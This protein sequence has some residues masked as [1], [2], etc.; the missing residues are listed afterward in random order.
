MKI[1]VSNLPVLRTQENLIKKINSTNAVLPAHLRSRTL[2]A[3]KSRV[4]VGS[5]G[6]KTMASLFAGKNKR[7]TSG[8]NTPVN[9]ENESSFGTDSDDD[10]KK[11]SKRVSARKDKDKDK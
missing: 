7:S 4:N 5:G 2:H 10:S 8:M 9:D 1:V 11:R 3:K 6:M